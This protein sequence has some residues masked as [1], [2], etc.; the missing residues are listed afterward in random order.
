MDEFGKSSN[1]RFFMSHALPYTGSLVRQHDP[2]RFFLTLLQPAAVRP[3][4]WA[5]LAFNYEVAK[6][7]EVVSEPTL[8]Y[9]RLQ[10]WRDALINLYAGNK[11]P[12]H[13]I[14]EPLA[15]AIQ[16][17]A[18]PYIFFDALLAGR[19]FDLE[20]KT[21]A[22]ITEMKFYITGTAAPLIKLMLKIC[23]EAED[24]VDHITKA[25]GIAGLMRAIPFHAQQGRCF[26]PVELASRDDLFR[27]D[28]IRN[29]VLTA[30]HNEVCAE[31]VD[32]AYFQSQLLKS[33]GKAT[34]LY[35]RHMNRLNYD[36]LDQRYAATPAFFHLRM[37][38]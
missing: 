16:L 37:L 30:L 31:L 8:G 2:E 21:P 11:P 23:G 29:S 4:L 38:F 14:L 27:D 35:L 26:V 32:A 20:D 24:G 9:I 15:E 17:Y 13:E 22:T 10:W 34:H 18:L 12:K 25:Y 33:L 19:E 5:L 1:K 36:L 28:E 3:A 7:R 6:T